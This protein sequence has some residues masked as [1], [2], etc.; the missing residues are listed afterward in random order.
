M[1]KKIART[2]LQV[3]RQ[4]LAEEEALESNDYGTPPFGYADLHKVFEIFAREGGGAQRPDY[5]WGALQ[6]INLECV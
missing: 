4:W 6:G 3:T 1:L 5:A 2:A